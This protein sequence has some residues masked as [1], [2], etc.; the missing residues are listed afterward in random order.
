ML[1]QHNCIDVESCVRVVSYNNAHFPQEKHEERENKLKSIDAKIKASQA[2]K[3]Q[4]SSFRA[5][6]NCGDN[7]MLCLTRSLGRAV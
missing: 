6:Y 5:N 2:A 4:G 3:Q 1:R 7:C